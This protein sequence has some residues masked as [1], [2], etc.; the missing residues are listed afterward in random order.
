MRQSF[1]APSVS[2]RTRLSAD[3]DGELKGK[4][5]TWTGLTECNIQGLSQTNRL[6]SPFP[7]ILALCDGW[8]GQLGTTWLSGCFVLDINEKAYGS[9]GVAFITGPGYIEWS[10]LP[11][12]RHVYRSCGLYIDSP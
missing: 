12:P 9:C 5:P 2:E 11:F 8:Q 6:V 7:C 3:N 4:Y 1:H 10:S